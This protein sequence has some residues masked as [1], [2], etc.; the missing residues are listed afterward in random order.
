MSAIRPLRVAAL[1]LALPGLGRVTLEAQVPRDPTP[2]VA[3][4]SPADIAAGKVLY[5]ATCSK[6]HGLDGGGS[7]GPSLQGVA[8][9]LGDEAVGSIIRGG[10]PGTGMNGFG[11]LSVDETGQVVGYLRTLG[12][13]AD[14]EVAKGDPGK[15][16]AVYE[17]SGCTGCHIVDGNGG[18]VGPELTRV[19]SM[20]GP[21]YLRATLVTPGAILPK[22]AGAMERGRFTQFLFVHVVTKDGHSFEGTRVYEDSFT[23]EIKDAAGKFY[24]FKKLDLQKLEKLP[25]HSVMPSFKGTL[26][27]TQL[28]DLVAYIASLK[29][30]PTP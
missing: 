27:D 8:E 1:M 25:G 11:S 2:V 5:E 12:R 18:G 3:K 19:G 30:T 4:T 26:S 21:S 14:A 22:E 29:G 7:D 28:D 6:C 24:G 16:K 9:R 23:I 15:G 13:T 10:I 17:S 20:R